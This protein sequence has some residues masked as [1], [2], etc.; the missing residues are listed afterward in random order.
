MKRAVL[1]LKWG[2]LRSLLPSI[3]TPSAFT[4]LFLPRPKPSQITLESLQRDSSLLTSFSPLLHSL[5]FSTTPLPNLH[6]DGVIEDGESSDGWEEEDEGVEPQIGDGGDGGGVVLGD[7][8]WGERTLSVAREVLLQ[9]GDDMDLYAF[10]TSPR[11]YIYVRLDKISNKY[12]CPSMDEIENF[13]S[14]YKKRLEEIGEQGE[15]SEDLAVE[16]SSPGAER[17]LKVPDELD[18]FKEMP[19]RVCYVEGEPASKNKEKDGVFMVE[20]VETESEHCVWKLADVRENRDAASKG[21]LLSRKQK[22]WRLRLP[23]GML[24]KVT[25]YIEL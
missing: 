5:P 21:R 23:F 11:G 20:S 25:L 16:V 14:L 4:Q 22:D 17:I 15:I 18:R 6:L 7:V 24:R 12:G 3:S 19:M 9:F 8:P 1:K 10:K 13:S 2:G